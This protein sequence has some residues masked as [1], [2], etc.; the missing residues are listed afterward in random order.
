M[1]GSIITSV[2]GWKLKDL[3]IYIQ[4]MKMYAEFEINSPKLQSCLLKHCLERCYMIIE[5]GIMPLNKMSDYTMQ[6]NTIF[7]LLLG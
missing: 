4:L 7:S 5:R 1:F 3:K 2:L 6:Q